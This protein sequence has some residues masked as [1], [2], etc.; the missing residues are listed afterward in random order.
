[1]FDVLV[2]IGQTCNI[3]FLMQNAKIKKA[4]SLFEWF[5]SP[6]L[7]DVIDILHK[8]SNHDDDDIVTYK[9]GHIYIGNHIYSGHYTCEEFKPI[10]QRRRDRFLNTILSSKKILFCRFEANVIDYNKED[11]DRFIN[12]ILT[13]NPHLEDVQLLM[14]APRLELEH[15]KLI[16]V[17]YENHG[18]PYCENPHINELFVNTL[19][20][21]GYDICDT[22]DTRFTDKSDFGTDEQATLL[23]PSE[24]AGG[25]GNA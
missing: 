15:P 2:P 14:I 16:K 1:M 7:N 4:T 12:L 19:Q 25:D 17:I 11:V 22:N 8:I 6:N 21:H 3:T 10:Y 5:V 9:N 13:I 20:A 23:L 18:D 24:A